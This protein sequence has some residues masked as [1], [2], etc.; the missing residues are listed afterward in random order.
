MRHEAD[1]R[2]DALAREHPLQSLLARGQGISAQV[3]AI[4]EQEIEGVEDEVVGLALRQRCL[5]RSEI[6]RAV[7]IEGDDL[8]VDDRVG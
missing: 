8:A 1:H 3:L 5:E 7:V 2:V 6:G 4:A